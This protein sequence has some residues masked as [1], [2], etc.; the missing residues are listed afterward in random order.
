MESK[1]ILTSKTIGVN[2]VAGIALLLQN[3][4]GYVMDVELQGA[5]LIFINLLLR[6][7]TK[8]AI[9]WKVKN[10]GILLVALISAALFAGCG[11]TGGIICSNIPEGQDSAI[12]KIADKMNT[13]PEQISQVLQVANFAALESDLY[14]AREAEEFVDRIIRDISEFRETGKTLTYIKA[15]EYLNSKFSLLSPRAQVVFSL[16][17]PGDL[18]SKEINVPLGDYDLSLILRHLEKQEIIIAAYLK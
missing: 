5:I 15:I 6:F 4:Y 8:K 3:R 14:T 18:A 2:I 10:T 16:I 1:S 12:C 11:T 9:A 7:V 17:N 13:T